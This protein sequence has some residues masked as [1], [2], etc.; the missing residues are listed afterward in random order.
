HMELKYLVN[1]P[2]LQGCI[3]RWVLLFQDFDFTVVV[4]PRKSNS[5][6]DHLSRISSG[7]DAHAIEKTMLDAQLYRLQCTPMELEDIFVF[8]RTSMAL[9]GMKSLEKK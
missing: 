9:E 2:I 7:E 1:K 3:C 4:K 5:G 8:L 6:L